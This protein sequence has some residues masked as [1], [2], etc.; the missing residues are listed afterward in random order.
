MLGESY[1]VM[2]MQY[3]AKRLITDK[4]FDEAIKSSGKKAILC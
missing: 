1:Y 2:F 3:S 4:Y